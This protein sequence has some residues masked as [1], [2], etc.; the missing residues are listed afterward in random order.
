MHYSHSSRRTFL[1][2]SVAGTAGLFLPVR[3]IAAAPD[4]ATA[5]CTLDPELTQGPYYLDRGILRRNVTEGKPGLPLRLRLTVLDA[6]RCIPLENAALEIWHC[7]ASGIY[8]GYTKMNPNGPPGMGPRPGGPGGRPAGPPPDFVRGSGP[9]PDFGSPASTDNTSFCRG[10]QL[11]NAKGIVEFDTIY[12]G[13]YAGRDIHIHL[14]VHCG[15]VIKNDKIAGGHVSHTGQLFFPDEL[16]DVVANLKPYAA[17]RNVERTRLNDDMVFDD[18]HG[19]GVILGLKRIEPGSLQ[20]GLIGMA[21]VR[22][23]P[24]LMPR[25]EHGP[26]RAP[27]PRNN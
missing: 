25:D 24:D 1:F 6:R 23:D 12:P 20:G 9:P 14:K 4:S 8:S 15:G 26:G 10:L 18:A 11:S 2:S 5:S 27:G 7:D 21:T 3:A 16:S 22:V 13:W 17:R 19:A